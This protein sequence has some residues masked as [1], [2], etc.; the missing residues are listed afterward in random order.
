MEAACGAWRTAWLGTSRFGPASG[1][2][3]TVTWARSVA[4][5]ASAAM[6][7]RRVLVVAGAV[8]ALWLLS[9]LV[10]GR[11]QAVSADGDPTVPDARRVVAELVSGRPA[12]GTVVAPEKPRSDPRETSVTQ[13]VPA[14]LPPVG[15]VEPVVSRVTKPVAAA[16]GSGVVTP[17]ASN[18]AEP[19]SVLVAPVLS[20]V[21]RPVSALVRPVVTEIVRPVT[22]PVEPVVGDLVR[23]V[24]G[25]LDPVI[26]DQ[27][28]PAPAAQEPVAGDPARPVGSRAGPVPTKPSPAVADPAPPALSAFEP[29]SVGPSAKAAAPKR[30]TPRTATSARPAGPEQQ[31]RPR[32][33]E[34]PGHPGSVPPPADSAGGSGS[35]TPAAFLASDGQ[36]A[37]PRACTPPIGDFATL[38]RPSE[39]GAG[40]G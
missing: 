8:A 15:I 6:T 22:G 17:V 28:A 10:P 3:P 33:A 36:T 2:S 7:A 38:Q 21:T 27:G 4:P 32:P 37:E 5:P 35:A 26:G 31:R 30:A 18:V 20:G 23:P 14:S 29:A 9:W 1:G 40:P 39:P 34:K 24:A 13:A 12:P 19:V 25:V 16:V 11:A